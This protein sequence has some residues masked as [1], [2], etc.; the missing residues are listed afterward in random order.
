M[1]KQKATSPRLEVETF[2]GEIIYKLAIVHSYVNCR[3]MWVESLS[4]QFVDLGF[5][6]HSLG[7]RAARCIN[8]ARQNATMNHHP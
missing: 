4:H 6:E 5:R 1:G 8:K 3:R 7:N 2:N